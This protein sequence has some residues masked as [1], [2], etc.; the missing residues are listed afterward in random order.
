MNLLT[1]L[2][3]LLFGGDVERLGDREW[4]VRDTAHRR[5]EGAGVLAWPAVFMGRAT[6]NAE[7]ANRIDV[8]LR[9]VPTPRELGVLAFGRQRDMPDSFVATLARQMLDDREL[10]A[11]VFG[12]VDARHG[13][14]CVNSRLWAETQPYV[15]GTREKEFAYVL[16]AARRAWFTPE[17][18]PVPMPMPRVI[19]PQP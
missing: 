6:A 14:H 4:V 16:F 15:T 2:S 17:P 11:W 7:A 12:E 13:F 18:V 19:F 3:A 5:L 8:L 10:A 1:M 9:H